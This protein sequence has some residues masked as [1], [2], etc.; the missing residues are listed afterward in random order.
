MDTTQENRYLCPHCGKPFELSEPSLTWH[1]CPHCAGKVNSDVQDAYARARANYEAAS[2]AKVTIVS[3]KYKS[4]EQFTPREKDIL[5]TYEQA[6]TGLQ[7]A[8]RAELP[9]RLHRSGIEMMAEMSSLF[10]MRR[11]ISPLEAKYWRQ[12]MT[13]QTARE[14]LDEL[15]EKLESKRLGL[16][17]AV[18]RLHWRLRHRQLKRALQKLD[19]EIQHLE[20]LIVFVERPH[21]RG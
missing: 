13:E 5:R 18:R 21:T 1:S 17:Q 20:E 16:I 19:Q 7:V 9:E 12:L 11:I 4:R 6:Y 10:E 3:A 15:G 2:N 14:E 8:F